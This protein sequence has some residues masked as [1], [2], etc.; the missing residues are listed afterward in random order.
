MGGCRKHPPPRG[1]KNIHRSQTS[2]KDRDNQL[3]GQAARPARWAASERPIGQAVGPDGRPAGGQSARRPSRAVGQ[4]GAVAPGWSWGRHTSIALSF[5]VVRSN[6]GVNSVCKC[7]ADAE[8]VDS[9][10]LLAPPWGSAVD[11][12]MTSGATDL[13]PNRAPVRSCPLK[14]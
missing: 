5:E 13:R 3:F 14:Q 12:G 11:L 7:V 1:A 2:D 10:T 9:I 4:G 8:F 6:S